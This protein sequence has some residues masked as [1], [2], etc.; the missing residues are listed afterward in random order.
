[1]RLINV[2][3][4]GAKY[5]IKGEFLDETDVD[6]VVVALV[7]LARRVSCHTHYYVLFISSAI[8]MELLIPFQSIFSTLYFFMFF[9]NVIIL[10]SR[11]VPKA[12]A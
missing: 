8:S 11:L 4:C 12:F 6:D 9:Y 1:M 10:L 2:Q 3:A 5:Y 7:D